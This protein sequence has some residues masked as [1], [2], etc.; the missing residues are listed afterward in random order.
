LLQGVTAA[1]VFEPAVPL[2]ANT[3]YRLIV[4]EGVRDLQGDHL[5]AE[6]AEEFTTGTTTVGEATAVTVLPDTIALAVG[7]QVQLVATA[8]DTNRTPI[9]GRPVT[10][11]VDNPA[12]A[13][14]STSGL[15]TAHA[16]GEARVQAELDGKRGY[17]VIAISAS[18][19]PVGSVE[20]R[21]DSATVVAGGLVQLTAVLRDAAGNVVRFRTVAWRT[22][23]PS[24]AT[25]REAAGGAA[26]VTGIS[27]GTATITATSEGKSATATVTTGT[28]G[29]YAQISAGSW[30]TCAVT[31][32]AS[33]WCWAGSPFGTNGELG[34]G[35]RLATSVPAAVAGDVRFSQVGGGAYSTCALTPG[36][37]AYCWGSNLLGALGS[38]GSAVDDDDPDAVQPAPVAVAG[39][40]QYSTIDATGDRVCALTT[41]G[42][43]YCWGYNHFG[44]LGLGTT[45]GPDLCLTNS[46]PCSRVPRA[47]LGGRTF[48]ALAAGYYHTCAL[49]ATG[50]AYCWGRGDYGALGDSTLFDRSSPVQVKGG[51]S[52]V[53]LTAGG[54]QTCGLT[55]DG[56]AYCWGANDFGELGIGTTT[57]PQGPCWSPVDPNRGVANCST[58]PVP[59]S[60]GLRF[61]AISAGGSQ[62]CALTPAAA[63]YCWGS[64]GLGESMPAPTAVAG[65]LTFASLSVGDGHAC[66]ITEAGVAY[67]WGLNFNGQLGNATKTDS[68]APVRVAGQ[69]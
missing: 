50:V 45:T 2:E 21:P 4:T 42:A 8:Q 69:P 29:P 60:G 39:G 1:A 20:M 43:A 31:V 61:S 54:T 10:W 23:S 47:V 18:L 32:D 62:V 55:S 58:V 34:N 53:A 67:C 35:T 16:E 15:V 66:G 5:D 27:A 44:E 51:L 57:G 33:A 65:S 7:S 6:V 22:S 48:T 19:A 24:V 68:D 59:V 56:S 9:V 11:S 46:E 36:G 12:V 37:A 40:R 52:F 38:G 13:S 28:V 30:H 17:A 41:S 3:Q 49:T 26:V 63:A 64:N 25:V 14:V